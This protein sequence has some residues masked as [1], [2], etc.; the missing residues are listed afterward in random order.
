METS[1]K[2]SMC[3]WLASSFCKIVN[4]VDDQAVTKGNSLLMPDEVDM[5]TTLRMSRYF[6]QLMRESYSHLSLKNFQ[7]FVEDQEELESLNINNS[8]QIKTF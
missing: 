5:L 4:A 8:L 1:S 6:M 3:T 2:G 7:D